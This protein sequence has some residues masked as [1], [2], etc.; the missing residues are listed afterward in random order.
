MLIVYHFMWKR[1]GMPHQQCEGCTHAQAA[2][3]SA[4]CAS[5]A[6]RDV[7]Y[8][9]FSSGPWEEIAACRDFMGWTTPWYST[10]GS[11]NVLLSGRVPAKRI[12]SDAGCC[13]QNREKDAWQQRA[14]DAADAGR[15]M[16]DRPWQ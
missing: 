3:N 15:Q 5:L 7:T 2:M 8:A 13:A 1:A 6:E 10:A 16:R 9:L 12:E 4:V 14:A 11:T